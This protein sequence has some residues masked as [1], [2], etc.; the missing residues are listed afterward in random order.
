MTPEEWTA[1]AT[2]LSAEHLTLSETDVVTCRGA[3][4][5]IHRLFKDAPTPLLDAYARVP[6]RL[7]CEAAQARTNDVIGGDFRWQ[8]LGKPDLLDWALSA[9]AQA[10][11]LDEV[12]FSMA[13]PHLGPVDSEDW[14]CANSRAYAIPRAR[15]RESIV[16]RDN[17][18]FTRRGI[19]HHRIVPEVLDAGYRVTLIPHDTAA[20]PP[21]EEIA[22]GAALFLGFG[23]ET[24]R[25]NNEFIVVGAT[26]ANA[27]ETVLRQLGAAYDD[28]CFAAMW[29]EL[30]ITPPLLELIQGT[31]VHRALSED[32]RTSLQLVVAGSWHIKEG[33]KVS[34]VAT[35][36][37]GYGDVLLQ[38]RKVLPYHDR[39]IGTEAIEPAIDVPV[40][41]T[42]DHLVGFGICKDFC[43]QGIM[44]A[45][46]DLDV[47][48]VLVPSMGNSVTMDGHQ[49]TAKRM[50][51]TFGTRAFVVQQAEAGLPADDQ[52]G[53]VLPFPNDPTGLP[54]SALRQPGEWQSYR[55]TIPRG[56]D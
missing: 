7:L 41:V 50:R 8:I 48:L 44:L 13:R 18:R 29:P 53:W 26:C 21:G 42:D 27:R 32:S 20:S 49:S 10:R 39:E 34:N 3:L 25:E 40:L 28:G 36:L 11:A 6:E 37:N 16:K 52:P 12:L 22:M 23:L 55:G 24:Q 17:Q 4:L 51:T 19:L 15:A 33:N 45:F 46:A 38:Y 56:R 43:D 9:G 35:V 30:T 5:G 31:L 14:R 2:A 1:R 47:D 54:T